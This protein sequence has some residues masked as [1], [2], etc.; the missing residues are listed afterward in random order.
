MPG[1]RLITIATIAAASVIATACTDSS[2]ESP[3]SPTNAAATKAL[4]NITAAVL[5]GPLAGLTGAQLAAFSRGAVVAADSFG[6]PEGIGPLF[7]G[8]Y[9]TDCH[10]NPVAG[11]IGDDVERHATAYR[12]GVC[13]PLTA[14]GGFVIQNQVIPAITTLFGFTSVPLPADRTGVGLRT[15]GQLFG[16][17]LMEAVPDEELIQLARQERFYPDRV[18]GTANI[19]ANGHVGRFGR[20]DN[21]SS[22]TD[23]VGGAF[24]NEMGITNPLH[25][26]EF[27]FIGGRT[28]PD[29]LQSH[30]LEV[31]QQQF[32]D[33][34][35]F[36]RFLA[37]APPGKPT[38]QTFFGQ[39]LF[40]R[41]GC[42][43]CHTPTLVTGRNE[44]RALN[45]VRFPIY[46]D[47]LLHDM[48]SRNADICLNN[49]TP[50][51]FRT[52]PLMGISLRNQFL[53]DGSAKTIEQ[54]ILLHGGQGSAARN[55]FNALS[56][57]Q[58]AAL[59]AYVGAL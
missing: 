21:E 43:S 47:L 7:N 32:N 37:A 14:E 11:G 44:V 54:A 13:D 46:S 40:S 16:R 1:S 15:T 25:P 27:G 26:K 59:L 35:S 52:E 41:T 56:S 34:V 36:V 24:I 31:N 6:V 19:L 50:S 39:A 3:V 51:Q 2:R 53:H 10:A 12:G 30:G 9:C 38:P 29:S 4:N 45:S 18:A 58:R 49:A 5:G 57:A 20:K 17:G 55:R 28:I 8:F 48:G 42:A 23:F 33:A 22:L